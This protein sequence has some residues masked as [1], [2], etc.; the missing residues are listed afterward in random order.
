MQPIALCFYSATGVHICIYLVYSSS[1][2]LLT[3]LP[4]FQNALSPTPTMGCVTS[5]AADE[6]SGKGKTTTADGGVGRQEAVSLSPTSSTQQALP[7]NRARVSV[8]SASSPYNGG[9]P[10]SPL[11]PQEPPGQYF[12]ARYAY[13][14][15]TA[16]DLSF[17][18]GESL[19][20]LGNTDGDWWHAKSLKTQREGY[21]PR[22]YVASASTYEAEE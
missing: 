16:E 21:I 12:I 6:T 10:V 18:K 8:A 4:S 7:A 15:R 20:V 19:L 22:N 3:L 13:Q 11:P 2:L 9:P 14:A 1:S 17:E 5:S